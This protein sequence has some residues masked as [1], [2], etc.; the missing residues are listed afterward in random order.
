M[1]D[2]EVTE[3]LAFIRRKTC[4]AFK[5]TLLA[6][7]V[8]KKVVD[9]TV[10]CQEEITKIVDKGDGKADAAAEPAADAEPAA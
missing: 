4:K 2:A 3:V 5:R 6:I 8:N 1:A 10:S 7:M 9:A